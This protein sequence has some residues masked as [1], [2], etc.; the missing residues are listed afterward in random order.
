MQKNAAPGAQ[1]GVRPGELVCRSADVHV[2]VV[3]DEVFWMDEFAVEPQRRGRV[4]KVLAFDK[5]VAQRAFVHALVEPGQKV[6]GASE[7]LQQ[8]VQGQISEFV[9]H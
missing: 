2:G 5:T 3:Q 7:R 1:H 4:G 8:G 6:F 9:S